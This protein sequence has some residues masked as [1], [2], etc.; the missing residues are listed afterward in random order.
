MMA[1]LLYLLQLLDDI[2]ELLYPPQHPCSHPRWRP[3]LLDNRPGRMCSVCHV[4]EYVEEY[5][6]YRQFGE[7]TYTMMLRRKR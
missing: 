1:V 7:A 3:M 6:F 4:E 5:A 2:D